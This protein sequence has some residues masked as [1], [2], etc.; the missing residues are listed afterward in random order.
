[1]SRAHR[2]STQDV[3]PDL[4]EVLQFAADGHLARC[5][6]GRVCGTGAAFHAFERDTVPTESASSEPQRWHLNPL[7][8]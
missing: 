4:D 7:W 3:I 6:R 5:R 2:L 1:M 8:N